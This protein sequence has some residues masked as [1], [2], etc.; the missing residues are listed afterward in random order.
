MEEV[1][2]GLQKSSDDF[3]FLKT[4]LYI[5]SYFLVDICQFFEAASL[6]ACEF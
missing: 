4:V 6:E 3:F 5:E 2:Q 1:N